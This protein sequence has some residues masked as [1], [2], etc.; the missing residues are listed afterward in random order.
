MPDNGSRLFGIACLIHLIGLPSIVSNT[1][2]KSIAISHLKIHAIH[3]P[4][5]LINEATSQS[6]LVN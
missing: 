1:W 4:I 6:Q 3:V 5:A 2:H